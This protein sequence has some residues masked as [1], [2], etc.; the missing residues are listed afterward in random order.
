MRGWKCAEPSTPRGLRCPLGSSQAWH[1]EIVEGP[2]FS[3]VSSGRHEAVRSLTA[4]R[5][6]GA[7]AAPEGF[8]DLLLGLLDRQADVV[9][10]FRL[11]PQQ[12]AQV[13]A[14]ADAPAPDPK[15]IPSRKGVRE[16]PIVSMPAR[17]PSYSPASCRPPRRPSPDRLDEHTEFVAR[18]RGHG[19]SP[20]N[21]ARRRCAHVCAAFPGRDPGIAFPPRRAA[22]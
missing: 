20:G 1:V 10:Q 15:D 9:D 12:P 8:C 14:K 18:R 7:G 21:S 16:S 5:S 19:C 6:I 4:A 17:R 3:A 11:V 22:C 2:N 13:F